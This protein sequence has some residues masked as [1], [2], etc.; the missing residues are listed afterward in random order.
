MYVEPSVLKTHYLEVCG[1]PMPQSTLAKWKR[2]GKIDCIPSKKHIG[3]FEYDFDQFKA[4]ISSSEYH[5][6]QESA[7]KR[8]SPD[9]YIGQMCGHLEIVSKVPQEEKQENYKGTLMYCKCH[10]CQRPD[11]VQVRFTYLT[12]NGNYQQYTCG[13]ARKERAFLA[14]CREGISQDFLN[15]YSNRFEEFLCIH[16]ILTSV[17]DKYYTD[18]P[19][20]EYEQAIRAIDDSEQ[21][22]SIYK[23]WRQNDKDDTYYDWAKPSVDH[24]IPKSKGGTN[25]I[26]NLHVVTLFENLCKRDMTWEEWTKFKEETHTTSDYF[27]ESIM[28]RRR[29]GL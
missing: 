27:L 15:N 10:K 22:H 8:E 19:I 18:C 3:Y 26:S 21:F 17:T 13:C 28:K 7:R 5:K 23:F 20:E 6:N 9:D 16:K 14:S 24:I 11:L 1:R 12:P 29:E 4:L 2:D 25:H